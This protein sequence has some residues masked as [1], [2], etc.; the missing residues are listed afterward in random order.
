MGVKKSE[1]EKLSDKELE[2]YIVDGNKFVKEANIY[3]YQILKSRGREF[4]E[5]ET[6]RIL[7]L[8]EDNSKINEIDIHQEYKRAAA[9]IYS[10]VIFGVFNVFLNSETLKSSVGIIL[11]LITLLIFIAIGYLIS[12]GIDWIKYV[13]LVLIILGAIG[14]PFI[15]MNLIYDPVN[16][17]V[18]LVQ[19]ILQISALVILFKIPKTVK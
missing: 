14:L 18:N 17:I 15:I 16:G 8:I 19:T 7:S 6:K 12:K 2:K 1:L 13:L 3:A 11:G 4:N 10:S 9:L 5:I